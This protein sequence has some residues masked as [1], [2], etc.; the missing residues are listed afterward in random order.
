MLKQLPPGTVRT[1]ATGKPAALMATVRWMPFREPYGEAHGCL[2]AIWRKV[3]PWASGG[4]HQHASRRPRI[5]A[6][7]SARPLSSREMCR[8]R[9]QSPTKPMTTTSAVSH[10]RDEGQQL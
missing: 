4:R 3:P 9:H 8:M 5:T 10:S 7:H 1:K 2:A 6:G